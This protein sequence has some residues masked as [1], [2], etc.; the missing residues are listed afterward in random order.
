MHANTGDTIVTERRISPA[1]TRHTAS[2]RR[3]RR[4]KPVLGILI[5]LVLA[6]CGGGS[7]TRVHD[8]PVLLEDV[9]LAPTTPAPPRAFTE[10]PT[11]AP[12][13]PTQTATQ[14]LV[15]A[16]T[17]P[18]T[19]TLPPSRTPT[20]TPTHTPTVTPSNTPV[21]TLTPWP[22]SPPALPPFATSMIIPVTIGPYNP[23]MPTAA[24]Y[25]TVPMFQ[26]PSPTPWLAYP[27][28]QGCTT[29]WFFTVPQPGTCPRSAPFASPGAM[30]AFENGYMLWIQAQSAIYVL[31]DDMGIPRWQVLRDTYTDAMPETDPAYN[32]PSP[33]TWQP[34]RGFGL[35]WRNTPELQQRVGWAVEQWEVPYTV[36][37]QLAEDGTLYL[38]DVS[39]GVFMLMPDGSDWARFAG[40]MQ[41]TPTH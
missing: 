9:T 18:V 21:P 15:D 31:Y 35:L 30:Q 12:T 27:P 28:P 1:G 38:S 29:A 22:T 26:Q 5:L 10:T 16:V 4:F 11:P 40:A 2:T 25:P 36:Q 3:M 13:F 41:P 33:E 39:G 19:P 34:R 6:A 37:M 14:P 20:D 24:I 32:P 23:T 17:V 7:P 8:G